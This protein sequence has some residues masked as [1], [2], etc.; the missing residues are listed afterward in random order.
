MARNTKPRGKL[1]RKFGENIFGNKKFDKVLAKKPHPP[2][3]HGKKRQRRLSDY[4]L[5]LKEKQKL[6][7]IY[8]VGERQFRRYYEDARKE[9]SSTGTKLLQILESRL[10]NLVFRAGF[11]PTRAAARQFVN[12]GHILVDNKKVSVPSYLVKPEQVISLSAKTQKI[13]LVSEL[14]QNKDINVPKWLKRKAIAAQLVRLPERDEI[15]IN[16]QEQLIV[17]FYSR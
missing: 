8:D 11:A 6:K 7:T 2:G 5:Q 9:R 16:I 4:G 13:P 3:A 12:H 1:V 14:L 17:E 10:D 15:D